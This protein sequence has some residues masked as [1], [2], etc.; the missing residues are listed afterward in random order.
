MAEPDNEQEEEKPKKTSIVMMA[1]IF[2]LITGIA[3][4]AGFGVGMFLKPG[5][6]MAAAD[7]GGEEGHTEG[8]EGEKKEGEGEDSTLSGRAKPLAPI[9]T[10]LAAPNDVWVR[11]EVAVVAEGDTTDAM[12]EDIHQDLLS[13]M[14]TTKLHQVEGPSGFLNLRAELDDRASIRSGGKVS[15]VLVRTII[16]E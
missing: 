4:G 8:E 7:D 6:E 3:A 13:Y 5:A 14:R 16:F 12:L 10:N 15:R 2:L 11:L 9:L 1:A